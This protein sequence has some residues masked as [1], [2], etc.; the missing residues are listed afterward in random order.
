M[1]V[2]KECAIAVRWRRIRIERKT[3]GKQGVVVGRG[4]RPRSA[5]GTRTSTPAASP[6][7]VGVRRPRVGIG[8]APS[9]DVAA[10]CGGGIEVVQRGL[11]GTALRLADGGGT[12][13]ACLCT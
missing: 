2:A 1:V 6:M 3:R 10:D 11:K 4:V 7:H 5:E 12:D 9:G 13:A 8:V